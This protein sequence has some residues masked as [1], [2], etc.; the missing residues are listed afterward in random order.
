MPVA[1][2][3][4]F[5]DMMRAFGILAVAALAMPV[6]AA[7]ADNAVTVYG[8]YRGGGGFTDVSTGQSLNLEDSGAIAASLDFAMDASRQYQ[9]F[10]SY[11]DTK[12]QNVPTTTGGAAASGNSLPTSVTYFHVGGTNFFAG[13]I[14]KG[15]YVV[16]GIGATLFQPSQSGYSS[17]WRPSMNIGLGYQ[18]PLGEQVALRAEVR[19]Y[20]T[21]VNSDGQFFCSGGCVVSIKGDAFTQGEA[22]I[23]LSARF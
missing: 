6:A 10:V 4:E 2:R 11:Q 18:W 7:A 21:L 19:G 20:V 17:E 9:F 14:G 22:L 16:G 15:G 23:G 5:T 12:I 3:A 13:Q 8:G 1:Q